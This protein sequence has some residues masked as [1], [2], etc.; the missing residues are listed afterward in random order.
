MVIITTSITHRLA[1]YGM[2]EAEGYV[3]G[4]SGT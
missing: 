1:N 3:A 2:E 4:I